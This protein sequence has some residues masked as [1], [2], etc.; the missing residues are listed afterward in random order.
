MLLYG[1]LTVYNDN[2]RFHN[3][4]LP[5]AT[6]GMLNTRHQPQDEKETEKSTAPGKGRGTRA[7]AGAGWMKQSQVNDLS[8]QQD[9]S[10]AALPDF[11]FWSGLLVSIVYPRNVLELKKRPRAVPET[12]DERQ[13][14]ID[15]TLE[16]KDNRRE[17]TDETQ[18]ARD[19]RRETIGKRQ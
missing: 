3:A 17:A 12:K 8:L 1:Q 11:S 14:T 15:K 18:Q 4:P 9:K 7:R 6:P 19:N 10:A 13:E 5:F 16:T 2:R